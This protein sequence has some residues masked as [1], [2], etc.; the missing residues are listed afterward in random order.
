MSRDK[1]I[2]MPHAGHFICAKW[3][4]FVLNTYVNGYIVSTVGELLLPESERRGILESRVS[5]GLGVYSKEEIETFKKVLEFKG[6]AFDDVYIPLLGFEDIGF[7][8]KYETMV[9]LAKRADDGEECCPWRADFGASDFKTEHYDTA[10]DA[11][12]GHYEICDEFDEK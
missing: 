10:R 7:R 4:R 6:D 1:W 2:W 9:F 3:C 12:E 8:S 5:M 11:R